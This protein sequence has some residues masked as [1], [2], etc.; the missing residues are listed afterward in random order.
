MQR[1][2]WQVFLG[3]SLVLLSAVLYGI[4]YAVFLDAHHIWIYALGDLAF[5]PIEVLLVSLIIH[6]VLG[7]RE[8]A[9]RLEK[10]NMVI[11]TF[12]SDTGSRLLTYLSDMDPRL[13]TIRD[14]LAVSESWTHREF[15]A[16]GERLKSH[17]YEIDI[18]KM[19]LEQLRGFL[20]GKRDLLLRIVENPTVLEHE[21]FAEL[22]RAVLH[23][24]D[25]LEYRGD[26]S[27]LPDSDLSHLANDIKR[28]YTLL[29]RQWVDYVKYLKSEYPY[30]FSLAMR[31][32]PFALDS[33]P[34][35]G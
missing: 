31:V 1:L 20:V 4:H 32:N 2:N 12:F 7:E 13:D 3:I 26:L 17:H 29:S 22:L 15:L 27:Q 28:V 11:G 23:L 10:L 21:S 9:V 33:T 5:L 25:E 19:E 18:R 35:V 14:H 8:K 24:L 30:L 34:L 6:Q 16:A